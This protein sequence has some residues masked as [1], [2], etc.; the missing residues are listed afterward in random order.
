MK[1]RQKKSGEGKD[2]DTVKTTIRVPKHLMDRVDALI[3]KDEIQL[4]K[5]VW[6]LRAIKE[7]LERAEKK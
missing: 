5:N 6:F 4:S 3:N 2:D 1:S 7:K